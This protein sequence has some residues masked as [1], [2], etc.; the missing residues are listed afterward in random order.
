MQ[1]KDV[2]ENRETTFIE[3]FVGSVFDNATEVAK[4]KVKAKKEARVGVKDRAVKHL[5][6]VRDMVVSSHLV[7]S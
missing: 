5:S 6:Y 4:N 1:N 3:I 7:D 2:G